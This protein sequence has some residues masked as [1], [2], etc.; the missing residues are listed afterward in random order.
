[1]LL[2]VTGKF[3]KGVSGEELKK[4]NEERGIPA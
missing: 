2:D 3:Y 4:K 1:M